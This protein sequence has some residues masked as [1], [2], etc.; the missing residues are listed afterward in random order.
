M[1]PKPAYEEIDS[2]L[3]GYDDARFQL[4]K[5]K[6]QKEQEAKR[7]P[8]PESAKDSLW[9]AQSPVS[10]VDNSLLDKTSSPPK[11]GGQPKTGGAPVLGGPPKVGDVTKGPS[12]P[13][14][15]GPPALGGLPISG[16][17][18]VLGYSTDE[19][20]SDKQPTIKRFPLPPISGGP[21]NTGPPPVLGAVPIEP[22]NVVIKQNYIRWDADILTLLNKLSGTE[23]KVYIFFVGKSY[24]YWKQPKNMC[25]CT[26]TIIS[27][28]T[29]ITGN[30]TLSKTIESLISKHLLQRLFTSHKPG[31]PSLYRV[32]LPCESPGVKSRTIIENV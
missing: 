18:L 19:H 2:P 23:F 8:A 31:Q 15:G 5:L 26:N 20:Q 7:I 11:V 29:G 21:P 27:E 22:G 16:G 30:S 32:F 9:N 14:L 28:S 25:S 10:P 1:T 13:S 12:A 17:G 4:A 6:K 24:G 3:P